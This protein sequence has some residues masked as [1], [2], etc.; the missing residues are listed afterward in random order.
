MS[1][2][3]WVLPYYGTLA[4]VQQTVNNWINA[5]WP[6]NKIDIGIEFLDMTGAWSPIDVITAKAAWAKSFGLGG[7]WGY[8]IDYQ[9]RNN[10]GQMQ[11]IYNGLGG[12][13]SLN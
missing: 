3:Y 1:Y 10:M 7:A 4:Q 13:I 12:I 5:G 2:D 6:K 9:Q 11:A 8:L